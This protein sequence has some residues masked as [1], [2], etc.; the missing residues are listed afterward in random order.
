MDDFL[1]KNPILYLVPGILL[2]ALLL[3]SVWQAWLKQQGQEKDGSVPDDSAPVPAET[4]SP[5]KADQNWH[6]LSTEAVLSTL[7]VDENQGLT[8][9]EIVRR[10][11]L[12][13]SNRLPESKPRSVFMRFIV[14]FHNLLLYVLIG[15]A[16]ITAILGHW[17]DTGVI[18]AV[19]LLNAVF[20]FI[21]EGK[22]EHALRAIRQMLS[23]QA[24]V[25]RDGRR[26]TVPAEELVPGDIVLLQPGDKVPAD[27]RLLKVKNLQI[28]EAVLTGESVPVEKSAEAVASDA[29][30]SDRLGMAYSGTLVTTGQASGLVVA[31]GAQ[32]EIGHISTLVSQVQT[33]TTP[34]LRQM[35]VFARWVTA[36]VLLLSIFMFT[37]GVLVRDFSAMDMF[38]IVVGIAVSAIPEGLPAILS[39]TLAIGVQR[40]ATRKAIIRRLPAVET[41]GA[42][43]VICT[44][45]T[46]TLT[47]NEMTVRSLVTAD[48][49]LEVTGT[50]YDPHGDFLH[51][52]LGVAVEPTSIP[53]QA[54]R[55]GLF[56]NDAALE[57]GEEEWRIHGDPMEAA[58]L[59]AA[60][61]A[62]LNAD[63]EGRNYPR[64][65][66]IPFD[67][68][69]RFMATM[70]HS[71]AGEALIFVKG[72]P[73]RLLEMCAQQ[74]SASGDQALN[75]HY[76]Q[77]QIELLARQGQRVLAAA[78]KPAPS[79]SQELNFEDLNNGLVLLGLFGLIDPPRT[80]A[81]AAI[82]EC[83]SAGIRVKMI[84][85]DHALTACSIAAQLNLVNSA[86]VITGHDMEQMNDDELRGRVQET[87]VYARV[88]PEH[89]LR[90]VSLLQTDG[91]CVAMTGDGVNDAPALRRAD[92]GIAMG[93]K[94][95]EA[96]KEASVMV[97]TD[98]NF[99]TIVHAVKEGR[100]VYENLKKAVAFMLPLN[101]GE[102]ISIIVAILLG[103]TLPITPLQ[104]LWVN[105]VSSIALAMTLAF[106]P[107]E[108]D[109]MTHPPRPANEPILSGFLAWRIL[110]VS[111]LFAAG[112]FGIFK[113]SLYQGSTLEEARTYA[114]NTLV[115][116]EVFYLFSVRYLRVSSFS[117]KRLFNS[118]AVLI[119]V[120]AV[121]IL[122]LVFT[123]ASFMEAFFDSRPV[124][125]VHG[126]EIIAIGVGMFGILELEKLFRRKVLA[127]CIA[128]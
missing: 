28:Q 112:I 119:G 10:C 56:C 126:M 122:Q 59:I 76:W 19:V 9:G 15:T 70:H 92:I 64:T 63:E 74:R 65:D 17:T 127:K 118:P 27:M 36:A 102:S 83:Q 46:G 38:M 73:E 90:L 96:A 31:T 94:G 117:F 16:S 6:A 101:G 52:G 1:S 78:C 4:I 100:A 26:I 25:Q 60:M 77:Q 105:M 87:D 2:S 35:A 113:W 32:T 55:A 68:E 66:L 40:L 103:Y 62:G 95:T 98:D 128:I 69:H 79:H 86:E 22:A 108:A 29:V 104:I 48:Q 23:A 109:S 89:K 18:L 72:A 37:F 7:A 75:S 111:A 82:K 81:I 93:H 45:K 67:S 54:L 99:A 44:D 61:K 116:M 34:L 21:Q 110:L 121:I 85:G 58:L 12:Y 13:G 57:Q 115:T 53:Q 33:L 84:T 71:H 39:V 120:T 114:V 30:L 14:Q 80:E 8:D 42:V 123:Y 106:E 50:G 3:L 47:R 51:D 49:V 20:G 97:I 125:L 41:L 43:S 88:S 124:D 5:Q 11:A 107:G 91:V 24:M